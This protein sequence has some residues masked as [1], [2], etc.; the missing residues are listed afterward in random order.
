M[1]FFA[2]M[3]ILITQ[4][5]L[6][7]RCGTELFTIEVAKELRHRG[8]EVVVFCP[9]F[10]DL[11]QILLNSGVPVKSKLAEIPWCPDVIHGQH[12]LQAMSAMTHFGTTPGIYY[13]HGVSPWVERPPEHP[14]IAS[15][16]VMCKWMELRMYSEFGIPDA[17]VCTI[18]NFVNTARFSRVRKP[19]Q[20]PTRAL[21]FGNTCLPLETLGKLE[22]SCRA[23]GISLE[24][25]GAGYGTLQPRPEMFLP[26]F[27]LVFATG[28]CAFEAIACGCAVIT[29]LPGLGGQLVTPENVDHWVYSNFGPRYYT[30]AAAIG[31]EWLE[32]ELANYSAISIAELTETVRREYTLN[33]TVERLVTLYTNAVAF[34]RGNS[35]PDLEIVPYLEKMTREVDLMWAENARMESIK[36]RCRELKLLNKKLRRSCDISENYL[37]KRF[38]GRWFLNKIKVRQDR[39]SVYS[40]N[41]S[42]QPAK[43][44][45]PAL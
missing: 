36:E 21:L 41:G 6:R 10:G 11:A 35:Q 13:C 30:S 15:Y 31:K 43:N 5:E 22:E 14:R 34:P 2:E 18:P 32:R 39:S 44:D 28:K 4:R 33:A 1:H 19:L 40:A 3:K 25:M 37:R 45:G 12:H 20:Q 42:A 7:H 27:D 16:V 23:A 26:E 8:H 17:K 29:L 38:I 24:K 9:R